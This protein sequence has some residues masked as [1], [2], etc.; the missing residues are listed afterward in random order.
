MTERSAENEPR[1]TTT[2]T[3]VGSQT[4]REWKGT[5]GVHATAPKYLKNDRKVLRFFAFFREGVAE[6]PEEGARARNATILYYLT[7]DTIEIIEPRQLN[8]GM[9]Q[10]CFLKRMKLFSQALGREYTETDLHISGKFEVFGRMFRICDCDAYT[11]EYFEEEH[12][13]ALPP[14]DPALL[15]ISVDPYSEK[16]IAIHNAG[17]GESN[18][19]YGQMKSPM[20]S[21]MEANLGNPPQ[22]GEAKAR[23][24]AN[25]R[26]VL[27]FNL[28]YE[29]RDKVR[30]SR[31]LYHYTLC[32]NTIRYYTLVVRRS[33]GVYAIH[34]TLYTTHTLYYTRSIRLLTCAFH[35]LHLDP[36]H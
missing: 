23:F 31:A 9:P 6:S 15:A 10:G 2:A 34:Y 3:A 20:K 24:L 14:A 26:K 19:S 35:F 30:W 21:F 13:Y 27:S 16:R 33:G 11:R 28:E 29:N 1:W 36:I 8:A 18:K 25:D 32:T 7:D 22:N 4:Q 17:G 12:G 5:E